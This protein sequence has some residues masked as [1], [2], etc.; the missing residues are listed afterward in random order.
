MALCVPFQLPRVGA[1]SWEWGDRLEFV[2]STHIA[3]KHPLAFFFIGKQAMLRA[4]LSN[5]LQG[6]AHASILKL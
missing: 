5:Q 6:N 1:Q 4:C 2:T 3:H